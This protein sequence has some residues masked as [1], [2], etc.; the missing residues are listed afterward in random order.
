VSAVPAE[1]EFDAVVVGGGPS[2]LAAASWLAR[3]RRRVLVVDSGDHRSD[4]VEHSHGY[5][6]R[7]PQT[8]RELIARGREEVLVYPDASIVADVVTSARRRPDGAFD[9]VLREAG[10]LV[11][12][13][14]VLACGV[15]DAK[16]DVPGLEEHYGASVFHCPACDGYE[17][18]DRDVVA[19]GW[20]ESLSGFATTLLGWARSVT[21]VTAGERFE[22]D[23]ATRR[24]LD[25]HGVEVVEERVVELVGPRGDLRAARLE[26]GRVLPCS[27]VFFSVAHRPRADLPSTLG[28]ELDDEG[29]VVVN[30][31]G[32]TSVDGVYAAGDLVPGLQLT[33]VAVAKG[34]VAGVG[35][36]QSFF[37]RATAVLAAEAAPDLPR[38]R[39][40]LTG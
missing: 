20:S 12:H 1:R 31:C 11:T 10:R 30:D 29:Y 28:C 13:R 26:S 40:E 24:L 38:E 33:S 21:V 3:F 22:G 39:A 19:L 34:V 2:G 25:E 37:G 7:D 27:L 23:R 5:L 17:A 4:K 8:P 18:R 6:G 9:V 35:C 36:A 16:P 14:L 15:V 32:M